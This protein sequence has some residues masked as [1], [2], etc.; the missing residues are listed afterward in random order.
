MN[1]WTNE[2]T[3]ATEALFEARDQ[4]D[5]L[6]ET[7]LRQAGQLLALTIENAMLVEDPELEV[8]RRYSRL[9]EA[10]YAIENFTFN[11]QQRG[12]RVMPMILGPLLLEAMEYGTSGRRGS[13]ICWAISDAHRDAS[14]VGGV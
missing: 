2:A 3:G 11:C 14:E 6:Q 10:I 1:F 13:L 5:A 12:S 8:S 7:K 9:E 4:I